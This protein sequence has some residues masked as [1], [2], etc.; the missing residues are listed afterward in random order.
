MVETN[1]AV[2][3]LRRDKKKVQLSCD[4]ED[5]CDGYFTYRPLSN[6]PT[7]PPSLNTSAAQGLQNPLEDGERVKPKFLGESLPPPSD[8]TCFQS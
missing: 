5:E 7:P 4:S 3:M 6:L 2:V 8:I 1:R